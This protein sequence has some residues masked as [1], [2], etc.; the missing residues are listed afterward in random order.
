MRPFL[1]YPCK[2]L[3]TIRLACLAIV[4]MVFCGWTCSGFVGFDSCFDA[5]PQPEI[6]S[7]TPD[8]VWWG[9]DPVLLTVN[10][11]YFV[12]QS[13]VLWNG[14]PVLTTYLNSHQLQT[15]ITLETFDSLGGS[16]GSTV[17]I[18][19]RTPQ[20]ISTVGCTNG[21]TSGVIFLVI[22]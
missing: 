9:S 21:G 5:I 17:S 14:S 8:A 4:T 15:T 2:P 7:L 18:T 16:A 12:S 10:G 19:V 3:L 1:V 22:N 11:S 6:S 13:Q 20:S